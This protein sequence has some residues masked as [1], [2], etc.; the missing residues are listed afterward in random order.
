M[1]TTHFVLDM[2]AI[3]T[4]PLPGPGALGR[5][6]D[7]ME[8]HVRKNRRVMFRQA[9]DTV[10]NRLNDMC[11]WVE[12]MLRR[13]IS[14]RLSTFN[15]DYRRVLIPS[16]AAARALRSPAERALRRKMEP[17]LTNADRMFKEL[18]ASGMLSEEDLGLD[19]DGDSDML[20][21]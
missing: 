18:S 14:E 20:E 2:S 5:M 10:R 16:T 7:K 21:L 6:K 12:D 1:R 3:L 11:T 19:V 15:E 4:I 8:N 9:T 17:L 13:T